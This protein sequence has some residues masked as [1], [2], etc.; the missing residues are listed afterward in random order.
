MASRYSDEIIEE[1]RAGNDI[2]DI[3]SGYVKLTKR[4]SN[5]FGLCPFHNEKSPSFSVS[6]DKQMYYC[7]GCHA[8]G[9]VFTFLMQYENY[10]FQ[11]AVR[12]LAERADIKLPE[13]EYS[14]EMREKADRKAQLLEIN[15]EA[16]KYYYTK[17]RSPQGKAGM[18]YLHGRQ[19]SDDTIRAFGLGYAGRYSSELYRYL[20]S[21]GYDDRI[22]GESGL[23]HM[24]ERKGASDKFWNRVMFP[25]MDINNRVIGF[26]GRVMGDAKPKYLNSPETAVFEK[27]RNLYGLNIARRTRQNYL[28]LCEGYMDVIAMHQAG[29]TCAAASLGTSLTSGHCSL[30]KRFKSKVLLIYDSDDAGVN[31]ALRAI[32]MLRESGIESRIVDLK[33]YKDPDEFI[34]ALGAEAFEQRLHDAENS[35]MFEIRMKEREYNLNDPQGKSDF[36][37]D[38]AAHFMV[39]Q[40][41]IAIENYTD[42]IARRY[43][44]P[45]ETLEKAVRKAAM[46]KAGVRE[47][48]VPGSTRRVQKQKDTGDI[49]A[50]KLMMTWLINYPNLIDSLE[51]YLHTEDFTDDLTRKVAGM[52]FEQYKKTGKVSPA[53]ILNHF[54]E[55]EEQKKIAEMFNTEL[56]LD[57]G[58]DKRKALH[59]VLMR[60]KRSSLDVRLKNL[61]WSD[62]EEVRK[63][64]EERRK[65]EKFKISGIPEI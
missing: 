52:V 60:L 25:I 21:K 56:N 5:Y 37:N 58:E 28:I 36:L 29:F 31:A 62:M 30:I 18:E 20:R 7:F 51:E 14:P 43:M 41:E 26:G 34:K 32:P 33:P 39:L 40:D 1:V 2:V 54:E 24:D 53:Y 55:E 16:A 35:F 64:T 19:L 10:T 3:I 23:F 11:E 13:E 61:D 4:G 59:D 47:I 48:N 63:V 6:Q 38:A 27:S 44:F 12:Y 17:L 50:Q 8:G 46:K 42:E 57:S 15:R 9:S 22:L 65:F 45:K 49:K